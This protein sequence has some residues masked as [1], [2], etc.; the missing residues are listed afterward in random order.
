MEQRLV[1]FI[2]KKPPPDDPHN[3]LPKRM[4]VITPSTKF[5]RLALLTAAITA[6]D[7]IPVLSLRT[8]QNLKRNLRRYRGPSG[9]LT[10]NCLKLCDTGQ[11]RIVLEAS[12][13]HLLTKDDHFE[14]KQCKREMQ[15]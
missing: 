11:L 8:N 5:L 12:P 1:P 10:T 2:I 3:F 4:H 6:S 7:A 14:L 13:C 15:W 9:C